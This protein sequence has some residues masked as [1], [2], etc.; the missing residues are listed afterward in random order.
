MEQNT[1]NQK[2]F[3]AYKAMGSLLML[4]RVV[5]TLRQKSDN[6]VIRGSYIMVIDAIDN[7][8][9]SLEGLAD[10]YDRQSK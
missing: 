6:N 4:K 8:I 9:K 7:E 10:Y 2:A 1:N 5:E 3:D